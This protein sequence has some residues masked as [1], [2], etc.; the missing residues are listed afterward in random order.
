VPKNFKVIIIHGTGGNPDNNW[1]PWL[2]DKLITLSQNVIVP[3]FPTIKGQSL[4]AWQRAFKEQVGPMEPNMI[5]I[6][7]SYRCWLYFKSFR[8]FNHAY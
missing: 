5:L 3:S 1:F 4:N 2:K 7:H 6:G 8:N